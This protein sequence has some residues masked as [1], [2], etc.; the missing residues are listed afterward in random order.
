MTRK[1]RPRPKLDNIDAHVSNHA[2]RQYCAERQ[3][4]HE[5]KQFWQ[6]FEK[7][8]PKSQAW[9]E[10]RERTIN[11]WKQQN[12]EFG[13]ALHTAVILRDTALLKKYLAADKP[14]GPEDKQALAGFI[15]LQE[16]KIASLLK[17]S[18]GR[19]RREAERGIQH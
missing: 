16:K 1:K 11:A 17:R 4:Q 2:K 5:R 3:C 12:P 19:P 8:I 9:L 10:Y 18:V 14:L 15:E 13:D 7:R 6:E